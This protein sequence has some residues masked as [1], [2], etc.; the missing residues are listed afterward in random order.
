MRKLIILALS[1]SI[2]LVQAQP[3][4]ESFLEPTNEHMVDLGTITVL[5]TTVAHEL[6]KNDSVSNTPLSS[7]PEGNLKI[8]WQQTA[9][10]DVSWVFCLTEPMQGLIA[11]NEVSCGSNDHR[12]LYTF[13][14]ETLVGES[15]YDFRRGVLDGSCSY[16]KA[17]GVSHQISSRVGV[18]TI[19]ET[20]D[21]WV[22][23]V[24]TFT[25][26]KLSSKNTWGSSGIYSMGL[27]SWLSSCCG[28]G[29]SPTSDDSTVRRDGNPQRDVPG[30]GNTP[31]G[32]NP[33]GGRGTSRAI[34]RWQRCTQCSAKSGS[35]HC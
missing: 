11:N 15:S 12:Y 34:R 4:L 30:G 17:G 22:Q 19:Q 3:A 23:L 8:Q 7:I 29:G 28:C 10:E 24:T 18:S 32:T 31:G 13:T 27:G 33:G 5:H 2:G 35:K 16:L 6:S 9:G 21:S 25:E 26:L 14:P 20:S 1:S